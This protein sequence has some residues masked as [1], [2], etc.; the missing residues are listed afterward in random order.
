MTARP[1]QWSK[2]RPSTIATPACEEASAQQTVAIG[3]NASVA[4]S[5]Y[6]PRPQRKRQVPGASWR[7]WNSSSEWSTEVALPRAVYRYY[8]HRLA[9]SLPGDSLP[10]HIGVILDGHRRFAGDEGYSSYQDSYRWHGQARRV[11]WRRL[12]RA[13]WS[14][15]SHAESRAATRRSWGL[16]QGRFARVYA[17]ES[18]GGRP[19]ASH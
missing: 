2:W 17:E 5:Q 1:F 9:R 3:Q 18:P 16:G 13:R 15:G 7:C 10:R 8:E 6:V 4:A 19:V 11:G 14:T 12:A